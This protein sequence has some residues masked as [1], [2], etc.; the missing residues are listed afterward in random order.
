MDVKLR[1]YTSVLIVAIT[2]VMLI[3]STAFTIGTLYHKSEEAARSKLSFVAASY[4]NWLEQNKN[5]LLA[6][7]LAPELQKFCSVI[8]KKDKTFA[9]NRMNVTDNIENLLMSNLDSNFISVTNEN[10]DAY[11]YRGN[12]SIINTR[13]EEAYRKGLEESQLAKQR[14]STR[15]NFGNNFFGGSKYS[16]TIYQPVY[17]VTILDK[18]IGMLCMNINDNLLKSMENSV[19]LESVQTYLADSGGNLISLENGDDID[20]SFH[21]KFQ[22]REHGCIQ[23]RSNYYFFQKIRDWNYYVVSA[24]PMTELYKSS[25]DVAGIM[26]VVMVLLLAI[27]IMVIRRI[28]HK[29]YEQVS[30]IVEAMDHIARNELDYRIETDEMGA[31][32][33]K[34][35]NGFNNMID[36]INKL[37]V[38]VREEQ[39]Q[40]DQIRLQA[41]QSQIQPHF[42]YNTLECIHW[43]SSAEGNKQVSKLVMAL[44]AYYRISLSKGRDIITLREELMHIQYYLIIQN[45]RYGEL[46]TYETDVPEALKKIK[47]PKLTLQ[48]LVENALYHGIRIKEGQSGNLSL[49][50]SKSE[51]KILIRISDSGTGL[52]EQTINTMNDS[53]KRNDE[54]F[55]YGVRNVNKR[56]ELLFGTQYGLHYQLNEHG[57]AT[58]TI[59]LPSQF[60]Q[61]DKTVFKG[62]PGCTKY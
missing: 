15:I 54:Q 58:V 8:N 12:H 35:G 50:V 34:L 59:C 4:G 16:V 6:L 42:L 1:L 48:P 56:I 39:Y 11:V 47:I 44:A 2:M 5:T 40:I 32:F 51:E 49:T 28:V 41:L 24:V 43:Q 21:M 31:D 38:T 25:F 60:E 7:Q 61:T 14:G 3:I 52:D 55:G 9:T 19:K 20:T 18:Q 37:M 23:D 22:G 45:Q 13:Y 33:E 27:S 36:E 10:L 53:L 30:C 57:G 46:I 17:S 62:E 29:S 26:I